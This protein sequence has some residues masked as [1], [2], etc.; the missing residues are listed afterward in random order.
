MVW[1]PDY[2]DAAALRAYVRAADDDAYVAELGT[3][4]SRAVDGFCNRQ[5]G[6]LDAPAEFTYE[7]AR[8]V[9][10]RRGGRWLLEVDDIMNTTGLVVT[11]GGT[12]VTAGAAGYQL[13]ERNAVAKGYPYT[14]LTLADQP[15]G[16]VVVTA[17]FGWNSVP[18]AV[19]AAV[20]FQVNRWFIRRESPYGTAGSPAEGTEL[21]LSAVLDPDTRAVLAGGRVVRKR[22][23]R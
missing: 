17:R 20:R 19:I 23:P 1:A 22:M 18:A 15:D 2:V 6:Q 12:A 3:A 7:G 11:V 10:D 9:Y 14:H 5:F 16:D 4:A 13:A 8:A 21:R